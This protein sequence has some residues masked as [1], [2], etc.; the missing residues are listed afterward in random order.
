MDALTVADQAPRVRA[1]RIRGVA[2]PRKP[3]E[4]RRH[5]RPSSRMTRIE[6]SSNG[7]LVAWTSSRF[8]E[9]GMPSLQELV[10]MLDNCSAEPRQFARSKSAPTAP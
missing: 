2:Q 4:R 6:A 1:L 10:T 5:S 7:T 3:C 8:A 9:M